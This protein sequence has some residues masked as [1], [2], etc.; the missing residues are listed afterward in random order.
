MERD[1]G[2]EKGHQVPGT[3]P[4][5]RIPAL[6]RLRRH[7]VE[8]VDELPE[9]VDWILDRALQMDLITKD[10]YEDVKYVPGPRRRVRALLDIIDCR[11][12]LVADAF[13]S[14][15]SKSG[16]VADTDTGS[17]EYGTLV[18]KHRQVLLRRNQSMMPY[19]SRVGEKVHLL[20]LFT[21]LLL[22][23]GHHSTELKRHQ[24]LSLGQQRIQLQEGCQLAILPQQLFQQSPSRVLVTGV[25]GIGKTALLQ[26]LVYDWAGGQ[27][28]H[29]FQVVLQL[30]FRDL[31]LIDQPVS[32]RNLV[33]RKNG[34]LA[35]LLDL[36][37]EEA[38]KLLVVLDGFDE[39]KFC[40]IVDGD[41][42]VMDPDEE[43][44]LPDIINSLLRGELLPEASVLL[45]T[46]PTAVTYI[47]VETI[48]RFVVITG[49]SEKE[50]RNFFLKYYRDEGLSSRVFQLVKENHFL[51][52][53]CFIPA[54]CYIVCSVLKEQG[55]T[56]HNQ[57]KTMTD[58]YSRYL[59]MLLK[60]H[61]RP[62]P[63]GPG[64][65]T[66]MLHNLCRLAYSKLLQ[67][68]TLFCQHDLQAH[69]IQLNTFV[70][71][72]LDRTCVQEPDCVEGIF[73]FA[74]FTIQEFL[75]ALHYVLEPQP[76][77]DVLDM[78]TC[79]MD[80]GYLDIF[81]RFVSGLLSERN[82]SLLSKHLELG[83][84]TKLEDYHMWL[85]EGI[86]E[87]CEKG[88]S[89]LNLLHC[90][91]EQQNHSL[92]ERITPR[93]LHIHV[94]DNVL[95][96][97]DLSVLQYFLDLQIGDVVEL[98]V[99]A[100][101]ISG[102]GLRTLQPYLQQCES[103]WC[104]ENKLDS[105]AISCLCELLKSRNYRL[106]LLGI[107]GCS[108][109]YDGI[110]DFASVSSTNSTLKKV[111]FI[112]HSLEEGDTE[113]L[114]QELSPA[115]LGLIV[116]GFCD[117]RQLW[118]GWCD[119]V[120]QRCYTCTDDKL[121]H[122]LH[123]IF[124]CHRPSSRLWWVQQWCTALQELLQERIDRCRL[125]ETRRKLQKLQGTISLHC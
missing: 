26:K 51:F 40:S 119:W 81:H 72:F 59:T 113:R 61:A 24:L 29:N 84:V 35:K 90:L 43:A 58:I 42:Y 91:F 108:A 99:T 1:P 4:A 118:Q 16:G 115:A 3:G 116:A 8:L 123:K 14:L 80:L 112:G 63:Q 88:S 76:F 111:V 78:D 47:P 94:G 10:D 19:N 31:N 89:I 32:F 53:L 7:R 21:D 114:K 20:D 121:L 74:H 107:E 102:E 85:L 34:H 25:A 12:D 41:R 28:L 67:H 65:L 6:Q 48:D 2:G 93:S 73:S 45:T 106:K 52:T 49:F 55:A 15:F 17:G 70:N 87:S 50:I 36:V 95:C 5:G 117:D 66:Q 69:H 57:P 104:G 122:F 98:D 77:P 109:D 60:H 79:R 103:L 75:A 92:A 23:S 30:A 62:Q 71:S 120:R 110:L 97:V 82:Q 64:A 54:F 124:P 86:T 83:N 27:C 13:S 37:F 101:N 56:G 46:R 96:P 44:Q 39:F 22:V 125:A 68:D 38:Q 9:R 11:G 100:T 18:K 105:E 33:L